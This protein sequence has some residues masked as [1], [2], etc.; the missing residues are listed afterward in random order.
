MLAAREVVQEITGFSP[1]ELVF[2]HKV[3]G[4]LAA[5]AGGWIDSDPPAN[6][7]DYVNG[8]RKR[9]YTTR[10]LVKNKLLATQSKM[11]YLFDCK[12]EDRSFLPGDQF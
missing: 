9:L 11:K 6:L 2:A 4:P 8:F 1:N 5:L 10:E 3:K 12:T 7:V